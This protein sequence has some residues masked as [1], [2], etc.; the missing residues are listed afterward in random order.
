[1]VD[2]PILEDSL[3]SFVGIVPVPV[4]YGMTCGELARVVNEKGWLASTLPGISRKDSAVHAHLTVIP[5]EGW[6]RNMRWEET[7]L[8]W[9]P[10]SPNIPTS[11]TALVYPAT[12][13]LEATNVSEGRGTE[14]PF[15][16]IGAPFI[17]AG[18]FSTTLNGLHIP[19]VV[20]SPLEFT[21]VSSKYA[22][23]RCHGATIEVTDA[24]TFRP[25]LTGVHIIQQLQRLYSSSFKIKPDSFL[26]L[27]GSARGYAMLL[28]NDEPANIV[29]GWQDDLEKYKANVSRYLLY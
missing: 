9:I 22:G 4:V 18:E 1:M 14:R 19:G 28:R 6:K 7:G 5:L 10:P 25:G 17:H 3:R 27:F 24:A 20:F 15:Q 12:C 21:P 8:T 2:G 29:A 11:A 26:R 13:F 16:S 23:E